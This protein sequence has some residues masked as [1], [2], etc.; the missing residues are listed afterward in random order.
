MGE[1][2]YTLKKFLPFLFA[3]LLTSVCAAAPAS[4]TGPGA[5]AP[6]VGQS[7]NFAD[8]EGVD[9]VLTEVKAV[10]GTVRMDR[11][12]LEAINLGGAYTMR[13]ESGRLTGMG[14]PN[15]FNG[16][17]IAGEGRALSIGPAAATQMMAIVQPEG[18]AEHEFFTY[19]AKVSGWDLR[20]GRLELTSSS[21]NGAAILV[22][23]R[24]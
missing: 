17:Y 11:Q 10:S 7:F 14:A 2:M 16:P 19:L 22:F 21:E 3:V 24:S 12:K 18:L 13:F 23:T 9:W 1:N 20:E 6:A 5:P 4:E 15:R 8:A